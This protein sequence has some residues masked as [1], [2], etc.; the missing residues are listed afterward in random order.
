MKKHLTAKDLLKNYA[1]TLVM[2]LREDEYTDKDTTIKR[3]SMKVGWQIAETT[4][5]ITFICPSHKGHTNIVALGTV[6]EI[7][8]DGI[9]ISV[10]LSEFV[11]LLETIPL[12]DFGFRNL[13]IRSAKANYCNRLSNGKLFWSAFIWHTYVKNESI[14]SIGNICGLKIE[15]ILST[16]YKSINSYDKRTPADIFINAL[17]AKDN[18]KET[19][20]QPI[21]DNCSQYGINGSYEANVMAIE[22]AI[23]VER[24]IIMKEKPIIEH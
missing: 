15:G 16:V 2:A 7:T 1:N 6:K 11:D 19:L 9:L 20:L 10:M 5:Y 3:V 17:L 4:K 22:A 24:E 14:K 12:I 8:K 21:I 13:G 18:S 23:A